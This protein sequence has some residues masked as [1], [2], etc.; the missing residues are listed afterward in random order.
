MK[1]FI[2]QYVVVTAISA[3][4]TYLIAGI[5]ISAD[6]NFIYMDRDL[7]GG[8]DLAIGLNRIMSIE[9]Y[10]EGILD[11]E[12]SE[13]KEFEDVIKML[14]DAFS[15]GNIPKLPPV[16]KEKPKKEKKP[17]L[18]DFPDPENDGEVQ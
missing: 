7:S 14:E 9:Y 5:L 15:D 12:D 13:D 2:K 3:K 4:E 6:D 18:D 1:E 11:S 8:I 17:T 16:P 10:T